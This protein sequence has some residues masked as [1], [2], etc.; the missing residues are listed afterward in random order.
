MNRGRTYW[1]KYAGNSK[2]ITLYAIWEPNEYIL[3]FDLNDARFNYESTFAT[4]SWLDRIATYDEPYPKFPTGERV[5]YELIGFAATRNETLTPYKKQFITFASES[6]IYRYATNSTLYAI[7]L[8]NRYDLYFDYKAHD[9]TLYGL[10]ED[11]LLVSS[12]S[13]ATMSVT[14]DMPHTY[15]F[16]NDNFLATFPEPF[17]PGYE[18]VGWLENDYSH[19]DITLEELAD[20]YKQKCGNDFNI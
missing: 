14:F 4:L 6:T 8:N 16:D 11:E 17:R 2:Y 12:I 1:R 19:Y 9:F 5:G 18:F 20:N 10:T 3:Y 13:Y 15:D 7:W